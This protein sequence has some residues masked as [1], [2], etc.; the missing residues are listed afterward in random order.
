MS[1]DRCSYVL[2]GASGAARRSVLCWARCSALVREG[3]MVVMTVGL[4]R[5]SRMSQACPGGRPRE[6]DEPVS[7]STVT[8]GMA[9]HLYLEGL[10]RG[11]CCGRAAGLRT[12]QGG[13]APG[14]EGKLL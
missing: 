11:G 5:R 3:P 13:A 4:P 12:R 8:G 10:E 6:V 9:G 2:S 7:I 14:G 1:P